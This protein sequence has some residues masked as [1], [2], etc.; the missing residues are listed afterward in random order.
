MSILRSVTHTHKYTHT[1]TRTHLHQKEKDQFLLSHIQQSAFPLTTPQ[2]T[3][4]HDCET[5]HLKEF[6]P[7][8]Y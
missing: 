3:L 2:L 5:H 1:H 7:L 4:V 6:T 8:V